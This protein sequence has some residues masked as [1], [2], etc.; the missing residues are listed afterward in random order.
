[1]Q[2]VYRRCCGLD[3]HK[4][5]VV[6][7]VLITHEDGTVERQLRTFGTMTSDLLSLSDWLDCRGV[8][9]IALES[10]GV[11]WQPV[12]NILEAEARTIVL[13]NAQH[14]KAVP[15]RKTD[16][17]DSEWLADL[18]RH[19]LLRA[20]FI[21]PAPIR[22]LR[23]LTRYRKT[24][25]QER[26]RETTRLQKILEGANLK[27]ASVATNV[28]GVSGRDML[29]ALVAGEDDPEV[30]AELARMSLRKKLPQLRQ[31]LTGRVK[32][33][34]RV[35]IAQILGHIDYLSGAIAHLDEEIEA[36][37]APFAE[38]RALLQ[39]IPGVGAV[40]AAAIIAEIGVDMGR[41]PSA[42]HLASWAG[43]CPGNKQSAGKRLSGKT[44]K[45][46]T[47]LRGMLGELAWTS[48]RTAGTYFGAQFRRLARRRGA[49]RAAL[50]VAH[51]L[52]VVIYHVLRDKQPY[53]EL[54]ADYFDQLDAAQLER[55]HVRRLEQLGYSVSLTPTEAA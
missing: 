17:K 14:I 38:E 45:G 19:G 4:K 34:H 30:L 13:V 6:A 33:H 53:S 48:S 40:A 15:G 20:S 32:P 46:N 8:T 22:E 52:L 36:C 16:A 24:L 27:L 18:L 9:H 25:V 11:Y 31:A 10:T 12:Y 7:C 2:V 5:T 54:G 3:V 51:T 29:N 28:L 35:L 21:P 39:T 47:W 1:M 23:D 42:K 26:A 44:T 43:V 41:F 50:A 37:L 49:K 55:H